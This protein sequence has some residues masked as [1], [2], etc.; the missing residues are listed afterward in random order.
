[1]KTYLN[2][3]KGIVHPKGCDSHAKMEYIQLQHSLHSSLKP[4]I[5]QAGISR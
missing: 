4:N 2:R 3:E 5:K 1:M